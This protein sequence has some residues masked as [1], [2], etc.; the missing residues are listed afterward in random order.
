M[1]KLIS[2]GSEFEKNVAYSRAVV[3]GNLVFVSGTTGFD[4]TDMTISEDVAEQTEQCLQ[5]IEKALSEAESSLKDVVKVTYILPNKLD[6]EKCWPVLRKYFNEVRPAATMME[7]GLL[8]ERMKI[9]IEVMA[10]KA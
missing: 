2:S 3:H 10:I 7:A 1:K 4:Y 8:D 5:N 9:E 6:F